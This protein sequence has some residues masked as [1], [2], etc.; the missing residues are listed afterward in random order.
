MGFYATPFLRELLTTF[1]DFLGLFSI[2]ILCIIICYTVNWVRLEGGQE[3]YFPQNPVVG[4]S[5]REEGEGFLTQVGKSACIV[6]A[7]ER[8]SKGERVP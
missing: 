3:Q 2:F 6:L 4:P 5:R 8:H 1:T 7:K